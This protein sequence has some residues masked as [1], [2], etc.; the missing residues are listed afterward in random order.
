MSEEVKE[1]TKEEVKKK[2]KFDNVKTKDALYDAD[3]KQTVYLD[4]HKGSK[5]YDVSWEM[6]PL[7]DETFF[8]L[9]DEL[10]EN[11]RRLKDKVSTE[12]FMP[13]AEIGSTLAIKRHGYKERAD[14]KE[15]TKPADYVSIMNTILKAE[16]ITDEINTDELLDDSEETPVTLSVVFNGVEIRPIIYFKE[17]TQA[18]I[19]EFLAIMAQQ[20]QRNVLASA[21]KKSNERRMYELFTQLHAREE[22]YK[23]RVPAWHAVEAVKSFLDMQLG[24][25]GKFQAK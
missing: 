2:E 1:E 6:N 17:E 11:A 21:K 18:Q 7:D 25:L 12:I 14:W 16:I 9:T 23:S 22:K 24:R 20:P 19:D 8:T 3:A 10:P 15:K 4:I 5:V 13:L